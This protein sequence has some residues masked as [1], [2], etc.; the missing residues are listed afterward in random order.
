MKDFHFHQT[1]DESL[2]SFDVPAGYEIFG[3]P[4]DGKFESPSGVEFAWTLEGTRKRKGTW[5]A[6]AAAIG[7]PNIFGL[8]HGGRV[9]ELNAGGERLAKF[10]IGEQAGSIRV[11]KLVAGQASQFLTFGL[12][13]RAV[14][15]HDSEGELLWSYPKERD[16]EIKGVNDICPVDLDGDGLDEV[17]IGYNGFVGLHVLNSQGE[18]LWKNTKSGNIWHVAA[19]DVDGD[20]KPEVLSTCVTGKVQVFSGEGKHLRDLDPDF[21]AHMIRT[22]RQPEAKPALIVVAGGGNEPILALFD[23]KEKARGNWSYR[24]R[25]TR[26]W[27]LP[28][29]L[30][31]RCCFWTA[32]YGSSS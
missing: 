4:K 17:I 11:A 30:G 15:A 3:R 23:F 6:V 29:G 1:L 32:M 19:G 12:M 21:Y 25:S 27:S 10:K 16:D 8:E 22:W 20:G 13:Q 14:E 9:T 7:R 24:R 2:F 31:W 5:T 18:L 26:P 28:N